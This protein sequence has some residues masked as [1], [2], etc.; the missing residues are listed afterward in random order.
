MRRAPFRYVILATAP[1][2]E[3]KL[4]RLYSLALIN[5]ISAVNK[6]VARSKESE[7]VY[8]ELELETLVV[9]KTE[10]ARFVFCGP[11]SS[12]A[13]RFNPAL[14]F[15]CRFGDGVGEIEAVE[16]PEAV[17]VPDAVEEPSILDSL[18]AS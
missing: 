14:L 4:A 11:I 17:G 13:F 2:G 8:L 1:L 6:H 18:M 3:D 15:P 16:E 7:F 10:G 5:S 9:P 12:S